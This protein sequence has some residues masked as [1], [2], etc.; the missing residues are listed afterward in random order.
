MRPLQLPLRQRLPQHALD[1][2]I[3]ALAR[4]LDA[5][6][7]IRSEAEADMDLGPL[8]PEQ[9]NGSREK[10]NRLLAPG[11]SYRDGG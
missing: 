6:D 3:V 8:R 2:G 10:Q 11:K 1:T 9:E 7:H 5:F 4:R